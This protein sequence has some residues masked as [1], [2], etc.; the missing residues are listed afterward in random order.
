MSS[1][2]GTPPLLSLSLKKPRISY[3]SEMSS[4]HLTC[5]L[6]EWILHQ[7]E[8]SEV[9]NSFS[10]TQLIPQYSNSN[11][12]CIAL[13]LLWLK[14]WAIHYLVTFASGLYSYKTKKNRRKRKARRGGVRRYPIPPDQPTDSLARCCCCCCQLANHLGC[15]W[16]PSPGT[17]VLCSNSSCYYIL[18]HTQT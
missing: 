5:F 15:T 18:T 17:C 12:N 11:C 4:S 16:V 8:T 6:S 14:E 7:T 9:Q 10:K 13:L 1:V 2:R 3:T